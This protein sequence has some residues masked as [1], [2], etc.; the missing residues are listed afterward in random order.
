MIEFFFVVYNVVIDLM[1]KYFEGGVLFI[2]LYWWI[3]IELCE[4]CVM[5]KVF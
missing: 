4:V 5:L 3:G 1:V 2:R